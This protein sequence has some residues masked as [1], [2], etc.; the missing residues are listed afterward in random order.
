MHIGSIQE[1][2]YTFKC[3]DVS[4]AHITEKDNE[5]LGQED[6]AVNAAISAYGYEYGFYVYSSDGAT[7]EADFARMK[8]AGFS[9]E[10]LNL[11]RIAYER[12][13]KFLTLD[14]DG[15]IYNDLPQ[16]DW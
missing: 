2:P 13:C 8:E 15:P 10:L 12:G 14:R 16:F 1:N 7:S 3:L 11:I 4:T 9:E 6:L 5:L